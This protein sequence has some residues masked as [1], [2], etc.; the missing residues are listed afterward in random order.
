MVIVQNWFQHEVAPSG[1]KGS[2]FTKSDHQL[3]L[4][5]VKFSTIIIPSTKEFKDKSSINC[6]LNGSDPLDSLIPCI[7]FFL[8]YSLTRFTR[9]KLSTSNC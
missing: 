7:C 4:P 1:L 3:S 2:E 5:K 6:K 8:A 9:L